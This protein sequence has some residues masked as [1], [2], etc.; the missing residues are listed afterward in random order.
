MFTSMCCK[1][2]PKT[3]VKQRIATEDEH[4]V[5]K[6]DIRKGYEIEP[7]QFVIVAP[8]ELQR[9]K[10]KESRMITVARFVPVTVLGPE[11]YERPY[12][13]SPDG[14]AGEYFAL[15]EVLATGNTAG[16]VH[17]TMR[18]KAYVGA[19][20]AEDGYLVLN[21]LRYA[22]EVLSAAEL[23]APQG[24]AL[25]KKELRMADELV[26]AL[27][28]EFQ[29]EQFRDEYRERLMHFIQQKAKGRHPRLPVVKE[30]K[31]SGSLEEQL[32]QSLAT[33]KRGREKKVA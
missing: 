18:G 32:A 6:E 10:P 16:I 28:G 15:A 14:D 9:L 26:S 20:Q 17:W 33:M 1:E 3:R 11:W 12:Y 21:K 4:P 2:A 23:P 7:G 30:R 5:Q 29:P 13:V 24:R 19:L 25:D 27:E 22:E 31:A 8:D